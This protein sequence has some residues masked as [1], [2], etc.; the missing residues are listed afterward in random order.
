MNKTSLLFLLVVISISACG[1][2][3]GGSENTT[4]SI[5]STTSSTTTTTSGSGTTTTTSGGNTTSTTNQ[6]QYDLVNQGVPR[7]VNTSYIDLNKITQI[8][9]FRS[10]IGHSYT[11]GLE[12]CRSMKHYFGNPDQTALIYSPVDGVITKL[13]QEWAGIQI[14]IQS[15]SYPAFSFIIFHVALQPNLKLGDIVK[16][17]QILGNH[18]SN[19]TSSDIAV[20]VDTKEGLRLI[21]YIE[22]LSDQ[23]WAQLQARGIKNREQLI[24]SKQSRDASPLQC[25][26]EKFT[27]ID[28]LVT[29]IV[30]E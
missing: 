17:G 6:I 3:S 9:T 21:S 4:S 22:T 12:S 26:G 10:S 29:W 5:P 13:D 28:N 16:T 7:F 20:S 11:D 27:S 19:Q 14:R 8:S 2:G 18:I 15:S 1:G 30:L 23:G 25:E 24:I